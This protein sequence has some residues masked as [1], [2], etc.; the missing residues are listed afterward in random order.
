MIKKKRS[1]KAIDLFAGVGGSSCG[2]RAAGVKIA[3]AVDCWPLARDT[4]KSNF[5]RVEFLNSKCER[6]EL[7][8]LKKKIGSADLIIAS[9][10]CTSHTCAKGNAP[11]SEISRRTAFQVIRF[12][13]IFKPRWLVIENVVHMR[14]WKS[15]ENWLKKIRMLGYKVREQVINAADHGVPQARRRLFVLCDLEQ[16]PSE[17]K[18]TTRR[19][20]TAATFL[21]RNGHYRFSMLRAPK[22]AKATLQRADRAIGVLGNNKPFLLVYYGSDKAGGWQRVSVPLRTLT[23]LDRFAYVRPTKEGH[24]MRMLQVPEIKSA[25]GFPFEYLLEHGTRREKIKL[26]GNAVCPP[27]MA[28]V[29]RTLT[30]PNGA[31]H[32]NP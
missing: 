12:A 11:R 8:Q 4:Y 2:A 7:R 9:P 18:P 19:K 29:I 23:T 1:L 32:D 17:V 6:I 3:A 25:M 21:S 20:K 10:E 16:L 22:R 26:L 24:Q 27:A 28:A 14:S 13:K 5:P 30:L 31:R 15:Y